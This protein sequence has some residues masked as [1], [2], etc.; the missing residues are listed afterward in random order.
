MHSSEKLLRAAQ[1]L[2]QY[3]DTQPEGCVLAPDGDGGWVDVKE[4]RGYELAA[5]AIVE[6]EKRPP[7]DHVCGLMG[8]NP[9]IDPPCPGCE[10]VRNALG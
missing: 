10:R 6:A 8:Y 7:N 5:Q 4:L 1:D 2:K 3:I 9:M